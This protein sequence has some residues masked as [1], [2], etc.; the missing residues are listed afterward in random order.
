M[1]TVL[2]PDPHPSLHPFAEE[3]AAA[4]AAGADFVLGDVTSS[5]ISDA[6]IILTA[7]LPF[8]AD[9]LCRLERCRLIVRYGIG[10]DSIDLAAAT[11]CGIVVAN[12]P[13]YCVDE[14]SDHTAGLILSLAR[15][16]SW[17]DREVRAGNWGTVNQEFWGVRPMHELT[18]GVV[19]LGHIGRLVVRKMAGFGCR[20]L[21]HDPF[22]PASL[23]ESIGAIPAELDQLLSTSDI[24]TLHVPLTPANR[25]LID[26]RR[27]AMMKP[28][29]S[30]IN[31]SRGGVVD[32]AA[33]IE[34]L[35]TNVLFGA[36]LDVLEREPPAD[37]HP[38]FAID[39]MRVIVTPHFAASSEAVT[40]TAHRQVAEAMASVLRGEWPS[41]TMNPAVVPKQTL[42]RV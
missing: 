17:L 42:R 39:P 10:V 35:Q 2:V 4:A 8:P 40:P 14:V 11:E 26:A 38:L 20:I 12:A 22:L 19:G 27:L 7:A 21:G 13:T 24:V 30:L 32:E 25:H 41:A 1:T 36:A 33:L 3:R 16:I 29:A 6:E 37:N 28:T 15:R 5:S 31:T 18:I 9:T 34:A 23:I